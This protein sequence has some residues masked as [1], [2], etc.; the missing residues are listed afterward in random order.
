MKYSRNRDTEMS[1]G[2]KSREEKKV[3]KDLKKEKR[4]IN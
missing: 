1:E 2:R 3:N 4:I